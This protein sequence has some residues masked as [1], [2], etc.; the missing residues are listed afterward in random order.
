MKIMQQ[1]VSVKIPCNSLHIGKKKWMPKK[2]KTHKH[3]KI[4]YIYFVKN[5][6]IGLWLGKAETVL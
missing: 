6:I 4:E 1:C 2:P 3:S 5:K